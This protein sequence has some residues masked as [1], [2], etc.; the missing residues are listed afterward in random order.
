[1]IFL[2]TKHMNDCMS[3]YEIFQ[4]FGQINKDIGGVLSYLQK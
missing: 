1:M 3:L 2:N 4:R